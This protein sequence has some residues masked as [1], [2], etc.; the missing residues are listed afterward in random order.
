VNR[1]SA[2]YLNTA[3]AILTSLF[4]TAYCVPWRTS[5]GSG[6]EQDT[7]QS[8]VSERRAAVAKLKRA[9]SLPRMK[10]GRRPR[11]HLEGSSDG[12]RTQNEDRKE[13]EVTFVSE[14]KAEATTDSEKP[15]ITDLLPEPATVRKRRSRSR[16][17]S[18]GSRDFKLKAKG[19]QS[20]TLRPGHSP[21][22]SPLIRG[23]ESSADESPPLSVSSPPP[24]VSPIPSH[25]TE[26]QA[27]RLLMSNIP[28]LPE[29]P[30]FYPGTSPPT[31]ILP[32]L[33]A[34]AQQ[35]GLFRSNSA[36][37][38]IVALQKLTNGADS[39]D[40]SFPSPSST[41]P[42]SGLGRNN[43][44]SGGE[45]SVVRQV[46]LRRLAVRQKDGDVASGDDTA[47]TPVTPSLPSPLMTPS[48]VPDTPS[49]T[50]VKIPDPVTTLTI[51][52]S[53]P[54]SIR[55]RT[56]ERRTDSPMATVSNVPR[57]R[58]SVIIEPEDPPSILSGLPTVHGGP[59]VATRAAHSSDAPS[60]K[61]EYERDSAVGVPV[62]LSATPHT[63]TRLDRFPRS[64][65]PTP[66]KDKPFREEPEEEILFAAESRS[67]LRDAF[68]RE[69]SWV[70]EPG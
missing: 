62:Y 24:L 45:R 4:L 70:A 37:A 29:S 10:D 11:M 58:R 2:I 47:P 26:R 44:V 51:T 57:R 54:I 17:R 21:T 40:T 59:V 22:P 53:P 52:P 19:T 50:A 61:S 7:E 8:F 14:E 46:M 35:R 12:E 27:P 18:R 63:P 25:Y 32:S 39:Y 55:Q 1:Y 65:V 9:A 66:L 6:M 31:P 38:R 36:S 60:E 64:P 3:Y 69:I 67:Q 56:P 30:L 42:P 34:L 43:T 48:S 28:T 33:E 20:P 68:D 13:D 23:G 16:S 5:L 49:F 41:P 15:E